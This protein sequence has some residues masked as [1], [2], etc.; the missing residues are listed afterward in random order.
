MLFLSLTYV[1]PAND[2]MDAHYELLD[3]N[4]T[5]IFVYPSPPLSPEKM[6]KMFISNSLGFIQMIC[7]L[8]GAG[9]SKEPFFHFAGCF[10]PS[11]WIAIALSYII[12]AAIASYIQKSFYPYLYFYSILM[13]QSPKL[14]RIKFSKEYIILLTSWLLSSSIL[15]WAFTQEL[16]TYLFFAPSFDKIDS[17]EDLA[18][19]SL[20]GRIEEFYVFAGEP[21]E[22]YVGGNESSITSALKL[23][24]KVVD[25]Q[26]NEKEKWENETFPKLSSGK[27]ALVSDDAF[28]DYYWTTKLS[29]YPKL[30]R[31][32][33]NFM[34]LPYFIPLSNGASNDLKANVNKM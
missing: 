16:W 15:V 18:D 24:M 33:N 2:S 29:K 10:E 6:E 20:K 14:S 5:D 21:S 1:T 8:S 13:I 25:I 28:L 19:Y 31:A 27:F 32:K 12:T 3:S 26:N 7:I 11:C 22:E 34:S 30:Y 4:L 9:P 23:K 17:L